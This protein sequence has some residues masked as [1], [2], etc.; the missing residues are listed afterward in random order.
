MPRSQNWDSI[1][2]ASLASCSFLSPIGNGLVERT[3]VPIGAALE[4]AVFFL[5]DAKVTVSD[6]KKSDFQIRVGSES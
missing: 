4:D 6:R 1:F 5:F 2:V 3:R